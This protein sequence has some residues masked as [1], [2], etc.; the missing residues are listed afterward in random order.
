MHCLCCELVIDRTHPIRKQWWCF[1][2][3]LVVVLLV[4]WFLLVVVVVTRNGRRTNSACPGCSH[5][6]MLSITTHSVDRMLALLVLLLVPALSCYP[7][8]LY[9]TAVCQGGG[10]FIGRKP[11]SV[12]AVPTLSP[13]APHAR[14][15]IWGQTFGF[16]REQNNSKQPRRK[17]N[18]QRSFPLR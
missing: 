9:C 17:T 10:R 3:A 7:V 18:R 6:N 2:L 8:W 14:N 13:S 16:F 1:V 4:V 11:Q 5:K 12:T 15:S